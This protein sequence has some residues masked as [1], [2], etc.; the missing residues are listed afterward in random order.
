MH[1]TIQNKFVLVLTHFFTLPLIAKTNMAQA[2][3]VVLNTTGGLQKTPLINY[4]LLILSNYLY[5]THPAA[6]YIGFKKSGYQNPI[7][8][9]IRK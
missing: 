7:L 2:L 8:K 3:Q 4:I 9:F 6:V 5:N 1:C